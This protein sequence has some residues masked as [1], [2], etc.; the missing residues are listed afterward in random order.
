[1]E[2]TIQADQGEV[3]PVAGES[4]APV[5]VTPQSEAQSEVK[6]EKTVDPVQKRINQLTWKAHEAERRANA[7]VLAQQ[8]AEQRAQQ[9]WEQHQEMQRRATMPTPEQYNLDPRAYQQAVEAHNA[10]YLAQQKQ[11]YEQQVQRQQQETQQRQFAQAM[12][13]RV[14][15]AVQKFPDYQEVVSSP[16]L[17]SLPQ[18]NPPLFA[19]LMEHEQMPELT[20]YLGKN[21]A[22]AHR[23]AALPPGRAILEMGK[24]AAKLPAAQTSNAPAPP[25]KVGNAQR[26]DNSPRDSDSMADWL[27]KRQ[28]QL[29]R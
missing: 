18:V 11:A 16:A 23:I 4:S 26:S 3:L 2:D 15:E 20:Y 1:M 25:A 21:P 6:V 13:A 8:A 24:I 7:A 29:R 5:E 12:Q 9:M 17:P 22:E 27:R 14:A 28:A 19:A 10:Q